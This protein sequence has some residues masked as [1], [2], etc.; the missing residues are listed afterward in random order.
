VSFKAD[1]ET[2]PEQ[3]AFRVFVGDTVRAMFLPTTGGGARGD[4]MRARL[5]E[6]IRRSQGRMGDG[7]GDSQRGGAGRRG[8]TRGQPPTGR[9][10]DTLD[11]NGP[12]AAR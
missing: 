6:T 5:R 7:A 8:G 11:V 12:R 10:G 4:S 1:V 2:F 3:A 9:R